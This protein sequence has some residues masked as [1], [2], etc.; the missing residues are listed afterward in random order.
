M[1]VVMLVTAVVAPTFFSAQE[2]EAQ[3]PGPGTVAGGAIA[4]IAAVVFTGG[5]GLV[6]VLAAISGAGVGALYDIF[7][8]GNSWFADFVTALINFLTRLFTFAT[9]FLGHLFDQV[10]ELSF[11]F[12]YKK[13]E[14]IKKTW[15]LIRG[16]INMVLIFVLLYVAIGTMLQLSGVD[17]KRTVTGIIIAALLMNFSMFFTQIGIDISNVFTQRFYFAI[18]EQGNVQPAV[19]LLNKLGVNSVLKPDANVAKTSGQE[20]FIAIVALIYIFTVVKF[21]FQSSFLLLGRVVAFIILL[22]TS[23]VMFLGGILPFFQSYANKWRE[24]LI[25]QMIL[26]PVVLFFLYFVL[27]L[28]DVS[29]IAK[30]VAPVPGDW[31]PA[32]MVQFIVMI[33]ILNMGLS[34]AKKF[35]GEIGGALLDYGKA[36]FGTAVAVGLGGAALAGQVTLGSA[37]S[38]AL[39][40]FKKGETLTGFQKM[41]TATDFRRNWITKPFSKGTFDL[42]NAI[43]PGAGIGAAF[44]YGSKAF[45]DLT[46]G[47]SYGTAVSSNA[48]EREKRRLS[49]KDENIK[50][51]LAHT[52][53]KNKG[54]PDV[55]GNE[56]V[57]YLKSLDPDDLKAYF[58]EAT[59]RDRAALL[60]NV[61]NANQDNQTTKD[62]QGLLKGFYGGLD[63]NERENVDKTKELLVRE[64]AKNKLT[65]RDGVLQV[66][67]AE[68]DDALNELNTI[69]SKIKPGK[70][71]ASVLQGLFSDDPSEN[72]LPNLAPHQARAFLDR[73]TVVAIGGN[74]TLPH[75]M[76]QQVMKL[77]EDHADEDI[78]RLLNTNI[79]W[80]KFQ[81][82][83]T[84]GQTAA[85]SGGSNPNAGGSGYRQSSGGVWTR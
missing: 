15:E 25:N 17:A 76:R 54:S 45:G 20:L 42:R 7:S 10:L 31:D 53:A 3:S 46:G 18:N 50:E 39:R 14:I 64:T 61:D 66:G 16:L 72:V 32:G 85:N 79:G 60:H 5:I 51:N 22:A 29:A 71:R 21:F 38:E 30:S 9:G 41:L 55:M 52:R 1:L 80:L 33:V 24:T 36:V 74:E 12:P 44:G 65:T 37:A 57:K 49:Q 6:P 48:E 35:A 19:K 62:I 59:A 73:D 75:N 63:H 70:A 11:K 67:L 78:K 47:G 82:R 68:T 8:G 84:S 13:L 81:N 27:K 69:L 40:K 4:G 56:V 26:G 83:M 23:P 28:S 77:V 34:T 43:I 58:K 2:A